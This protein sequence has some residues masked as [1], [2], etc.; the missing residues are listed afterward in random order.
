MS[1]VRYHKAALIRHRSVID[2]LLADRSSRTSFCSCRLYLSDQAAP[3]R[4]GRPEEELEVADPHSDEAL[5]NFPDRSLVAWT[6][7]PLLIPF[8]RRIGNLN[9]VLRDVACFR[10]KTLLCFTLFWSSFDAR[11]Y[12][13]NVRILY[14]V[15]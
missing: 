8:D 14:N 9:C 5:Q 12:L 7:I 6:A 11:V 3:L 1:V 15:Q 10:S 13:R 4:E 2:L